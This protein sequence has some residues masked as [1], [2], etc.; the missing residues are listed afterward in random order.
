MKV[1]YIA[2]AKLELLLE[3]AEYDL[4][5]G[6]AAVLVCAAHVVLLR[7]IAREDS[8]AIELPH[9]PRQKT[10]DQDLAQRARAS[11]DQ[12]P[13]AFEWLCHCVLRM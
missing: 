3:I 4:V 5:G 6:A 1:A 11:S 8:H 10:P 9:F 2:D 12:Q 7:F 13:L